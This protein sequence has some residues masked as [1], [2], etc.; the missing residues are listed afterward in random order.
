[1]L[2][3]ESLIA[4][5]VVS[6]KS[7]VSLW[8]NRYLI[9][10]RNIGV[11]VIL[12]LLSRGDRHGFKSIFDTTRSPAAQKGFLFSCCSFHIGVRLVVWN[13]TPNAYTASFR[14]RQWVISSFLCFLERSS[15][16]GL[17]RHFGTWHHCLYFSSFLAGKIYIC[18]HFC[19]SYFFFLQCWSSF[20]LQSLC[21]LLFWMFL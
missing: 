16:L 14:S 2:Y 12:Y 10:N 6:G 4:S 18:C 5:I 3:I 9:F 19:I 17:C 13:T 8:Y 7:F 20:V 1:M 11:M 15:G 21:C